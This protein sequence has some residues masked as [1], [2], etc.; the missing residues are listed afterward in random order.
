MKKDFESLHQFLREEEAARLV[1][2]REN[3]E[4]RKREAEQQIHRMNQVIKS[5]E[6]KIQVVEEELDADGDGVEYLENYKDSMKSTCSGNKEPQQICRPLINVCEHLGNLQFTVWEKMKHVT[7]YTPVTFDPRTAGWSLRVAPGLNSVCIRPGP[8]QG[9][10]LSLDVSVPDSPKRFHPYSCILAREGFDSG[11]HC[12]DVQ[13]GD[14][15]NWTVGVAAQ[16]ASRRTE[17]E[18]SPEAGLWCIS[19]KDNKY[20]ALTAPSQDLNLDDTLQ[21]SSICVRLNWDEGTLDFKDVDTDTHLFTFRHRFTEKVYPYFESI[22]LFG[23]FAVSSQKVEVNVG[24]DFV[25]VEDTE[26]A[27]EIKRNNSVSLIYSNSTTPECG[28]LTEDKNTVICPVG[29]TSN[30]TV[31]VAAQ[32]ASRRTELEASPEAGLWCISLKD[33]KYQALTAPSQDLNLDDTLQL[34]SICVR[35]NWDEGT[36][37]FKDVDT[38]THLFTFRHRF[39]EKVYPYFESI[40]LFGGFAVSSQKVDVNVGSDFV[41]VEDTEEAEEIKRNNSVSLIYSNSTTPECGCLT[42]DKNTVICPVR[43]EKKSKPQRSAGKGKLVKIK[44]AGQEKTKENKASVKNQ[45]SKPKF[46][47]TYH[48]SLNRALH[49]I[50]KLSE[51]HEELSTTQ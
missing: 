13:V 15:S 43:E 31:G 51:H 23:G 44:P 33:N 29:D 2:L 38:D 8:S 22:S 39:T 9:L 4:E 26:E 49:F 30:W 10:D 41:P 6:E 24:S 48:V 17:L 19:L 21:L 36:L 35:L 7:P 37:D 46:S 34:S 5:L 40:S 16:S 11:V 14:T 45:N 18:A 28:C 25:P 32:S 42:E 27:E 3:K 20:Q 1:S 50:K 47:V 12:W